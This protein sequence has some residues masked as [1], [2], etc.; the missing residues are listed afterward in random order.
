MTDLSP[1]LI[2]VSD[3]QKMAQL[4]IRMFNLDRNDENMLVTKEN[5]NNKL[6]PIDHA[7]SLPNTLEDGAWFDWM[8]WKQAKQPI[9]KEILEY[10]ERISIEKDAEILKNLN[11]SEESINVMKMSTLALK[12]LAKNGYNMHEIA[13]FLTRPT[14]KELSP[15]EE[16]ER[17]SKKSGSQNFWDH[18]IKLLNERMS[19][20]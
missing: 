1:S 4:D 5:G 15:L 14:R 7:Y 13:V 17:D 20:K 18:F 10:I 6:V 19:P 11:F 9:S 16:I 12:T 8:N 2:S 3:V